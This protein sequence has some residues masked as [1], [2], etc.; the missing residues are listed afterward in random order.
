M[1]TDCFYV[2]DI[3]RIEQEDTNNSSDTG[4]AGAGAGVDD[5]S[6]KQRRLLL[7]VTFEVVFVKS[8]WFEELITRT[9]RS[10]VKKFMS[11]M[12]EYITDKYSR[13]GCITPVLRVPAPPVLPVGASAG[14]PTPAL[15]IENE[16][17]HNDDNAP[18]AAADTNIDAITTTTDAVE[19]V[20]EAA[21]A[22]AAAA[23]GT[24]KEATIA[25]STNDSTTTLPATATGTALTIKI[26]NKAVPRG[27]EKEKSSD[28]PLSYS[29][30]P[31]WFRPLSIFLLGSI[32]VLQIKVLSNINTLRGEVHELKQHTLMKLG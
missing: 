13:S 2:K 5:S 26:K 18:V 1:G 28:F 4:G 22:A 20:M 9:T 32:V 25:S 3:M 27:V 11:N 21:A 23:D 19:V 31:W 30:S 15:T 16:D 14:V 12:A 29:S 24:G 7:N 10:E 17:N 6:T 8:T